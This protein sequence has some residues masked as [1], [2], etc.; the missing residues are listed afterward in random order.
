M[1]YRMAEV[2]GYNV[3]AGPLPP[4]ALSEWLCPY[5][6]ERCNKSTQ[7]GQPLAVC[8]IIAH[9]TGS[10]PVP[11][12]PRRLWEGNDVFR[13]AD[14]LAFSYLGPHITARRKEVPFMR[15][16]QKRKKLASFDH[17]L[18]ARDSDGRILDY[19]AVE[20]QAVYF[21]GDEIRT[22]YL[23]FIRSGIVA[24]NR[25]RR[26]DYRSSS[27]KRLLPQLELKA[28]AIRRWGK[29]LFV[30]IDKEF[31]NTLNLDHFETSIDNADIV[32]LIYQICGTPND[33]QYKLQRVEHKFTTLE[34]VKVAVLRRRIPRRDEFES[35]LARGDWIQVV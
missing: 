13:W 24:T 17:V 28:D 30:A 7:G 15:H 25:R 10:L 2:L 11:T 35:E 29:R 22:E 20:V 32:W 21:S 31:F 23:E 1:S 5:A 18:A 12:C 3:A 14:T 27:V 34:E 16:P 8:S 26:P 4:E 19:C 6:S 9:E 33:R